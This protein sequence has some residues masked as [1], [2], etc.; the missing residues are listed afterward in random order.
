MFST[1]RAGTGTA[2]TTFRCVALMAM[3]SAASIAFST[4]EPSCGYG[5]VSD[6][7]L[8]RRSSPK[9]VLSYGDNVQ[10]VGVAKRRVTT[11]FDVRHLR[12]RVGSHQGFFFTLSSDNRTKKCL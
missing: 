5:S 8:I 11:A 3:S 7:F 10:R 2:S 1:I 12:Q 6:G 9:H 4:A